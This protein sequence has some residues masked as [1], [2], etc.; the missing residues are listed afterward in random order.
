VR[1]EPRT[2]RELVWL[3]ALAKARYARVLAAQ[4]AWIDEAHLEVMEDL[5]R[6]ARAAP[7]V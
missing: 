2:L 6:A 1:R 3:M 4:L 5:T 7:P